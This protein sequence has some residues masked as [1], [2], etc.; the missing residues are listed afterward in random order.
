MVDQS[1]IGRSTR[2]NPATYTKAF[3]GIRD[4][5]ASTRQAK[6]MGYTRSF[7][8]NVPG[9]RCETCQG[10][11]VQKI[12]MQFMADINLPVKYV[13]EHGTEKMY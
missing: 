11:G 5:F 8:F 12:E 10:E 3:D 9:G 13:M 1:P 4:V 2:S 6:I 7:S